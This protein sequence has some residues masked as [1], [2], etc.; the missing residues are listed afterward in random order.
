[1]VNLLLY[2]WKRKTLSSFGGYIDV[3]NIKLKIELWLKLL[4]SVN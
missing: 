1:M 3:L 4:I 2:F